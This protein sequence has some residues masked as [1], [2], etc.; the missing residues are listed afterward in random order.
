M[1]ESEAEVILDKF[2]ASWIEQDLIAFLDL[3]SDD[4]IYSESYGP[5]YSNK[6]ECEKWFKYWNK[7]SKVLQWIVKCF[8]FDQINSVIIF[9]WFFECNYKGAV[10]G[11]DGSSFMVIKDNK[12]SSVN[13]YKTESAHYF[14]FRTESNEIE[15]QDVSSNTFVYTTDSKWPD[16][17]ALVSLFKQTSW[18]QNRIPSDVSLLR[19][20]SD[21]VIS[22]Y[23]NTKLIGFGRIIT[24]GKYR[25]LLDDIIVDEQYRSKGIGRN[26]VK[27]LL[28]NAHNIEEVFLNTGKDHQVFYEKIGFKPFLGLTMVKANS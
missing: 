19:N 1:T 16:S 26:I 2:I 3:L 18:A 5:I 28:E 9:E 11:F 15:L 22:V 17:D 13:E 23:D 14:P 25:G 20:S 27:S 6:S 4:I 8:V 12:I 24:D 10:S 7:D 21:I